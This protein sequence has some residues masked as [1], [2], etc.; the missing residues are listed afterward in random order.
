VSNQAIRISGVVV[1]QNNQ[2]TIEAVIKNL[3]PLCD[4]IVVV[5]G[6]SQDATMSL[7]TQS[8]MVRLYRRPFDGNIGAQKNFAFDQCL[9]DWIL[10]LDTDE[11]LGGR[12]VERIRLLTRVPFMSWFAFPRYWLVEHEGQVKYLAAKRFYRDRQIRLFRNLPGF[13]YDTSRSPIHH[14]FVDKQGNGRPLRNPHIFHYTFLMQD[15]AQREAKVERYQEREPQSSELHRMYL[16]E[17][18]N[19][20]LALPQGPVPDLL[21]ADSR[22]HLHR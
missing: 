10:I 12:G 6:G 11:L 18:W 9:G 17:D 8:P 3:E 22:G 5:D 15:R 16:W 7:A 20:D 14:V 2:T 13:R 4:E 21:A 19:S 1:A